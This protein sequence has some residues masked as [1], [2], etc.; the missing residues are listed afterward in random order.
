MVRQC[1]TARGSSAERNP[2]AQ[3]CLFQ[4][5]AH[6]GKC[7][8][9]ASCP[10]SGRPRERC[11]SHI[12]ARL[13]FDAIQNR[14]YERCRIRRASRYGRS[15]RISTVI[16]R[17]RALV[18]RPCLGGF[19]PPNPIASCGPIAP[20]L[21]T[22]QGLSCRAERNRQCRVPGSDWPFAGQLPPSRASEGRVDRL[23]V[24]RRFGVS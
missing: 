12:D 1:A 21:R 11:P 22:I 18:V 17:R 19:A 23:G 24:G 4:A 8:A 5:V 15:G 3:H 2:A 20:I 13:Q 9:W 6:R 16:P 14:N 7:V 10:M